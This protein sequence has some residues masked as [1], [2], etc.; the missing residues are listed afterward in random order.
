MSEAKALAAIVR[1]FFSRQA[2]PLLARI[3]ALE[4]RA[5]VPGPKGDDGA[6]G[7]AGEPG[8]AGAPGK[9]GESIHPD[10]VRAMVADQ[11]RLQVAEIP[12]AKDGEPGRDAVAMEFR[13]GIDDGKSYPK[14]ASA[15]YR[16]GTVVALRA[17]DPL[18]ETAGDLAAA[19][20]GVM[21]NGT[22]ADVEESLDE[23]RTVRRTLTMTNGKAIVSERK[24][25]VTIYR[26]VWL[27]GREYSR[28]DMATRDGSVWHCEA[29]TT[30]VEPGNGKPEW[31]LAVKRGNHGRDAK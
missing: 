25:S 8:V 29:E 23:G 6:P 7:H 13:D 19:G 18:A 2:E 11:V 20:W 24:T 10:T 21:L 22:H 28:G 17:T 16:G 15:L 5:P 4:L 9:D 1:E 12:R 30:T 3:A 26:G 27:H 14:G 31:K